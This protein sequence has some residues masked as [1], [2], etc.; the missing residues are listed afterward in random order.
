MPLLFAEIL[1]DEINAND[2]QELYFGV[3]NIIKKYSGE[4]EAFEAIDEFIKVI[5]GGASL[6]EIIQ[7]AIDEAHNPTLA[8]DLTLNNSCETP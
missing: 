1:K 6:D 2:E 7:L 8:S 3:K 4:R 5:T